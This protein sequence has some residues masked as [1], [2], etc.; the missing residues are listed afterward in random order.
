VRTPRWK[1]IKRFGESRTP[2]LVN[3]DDSPSKD[4][5]VEAGWGEQAVDPEQLYDLLFD[6][7]EARNL[8]ADPATQPVKDELRAMLERWMEDTGDPLLDGPVPPPPGAEYNDPDQLSPGEPTHMI[9][10][11]TT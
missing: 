8:A 4:L 5:W 3:T 9:R 2:V 1:F 6:P 10:P 11:A 7:N